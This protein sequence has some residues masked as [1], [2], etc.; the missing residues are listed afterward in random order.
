[1][2]VPTRAII[3]LGP[4]SMEL[5][6]EVLMEPNGAAVGAT[7][8]DADEEDIDVGVAEITGTG[9]EVG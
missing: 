5:A 3:S 4:A 1:M 7:S 6:P 9:E 8:D 2:I